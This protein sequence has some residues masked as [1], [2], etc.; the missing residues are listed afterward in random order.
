MS[1]LQSKLRGLNS[2]I[3][4]DKNYRNRKALLQYAGIEITNWYVTIMLSNQTCFCLD[5]TH[6]L[7]IKNW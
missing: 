5:T 1:K 6:F 7:A 4:S 2:K 3:D